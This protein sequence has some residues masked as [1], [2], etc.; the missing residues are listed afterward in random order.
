MDLEEVEALM[1]AYSAPRRGL[2]VMLPLCLLL[3]SECV[4]PF[5]SISYTA[6]SD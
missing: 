2:C 4:T 5:F 1:E 6:H 3:D